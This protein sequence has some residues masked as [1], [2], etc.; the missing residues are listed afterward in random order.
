MLISNPFRR[1][2]LTL[3]VAFLVL[4]PTA[5]ARANDNETLETSQS[6]LERGAD[7]F[8]S[9]KVRPRI[10]F[11][12]QGMIEGD[13]GDAD[14]SWVRSGGSLSVAVPLSKSFVLV[15]RISG[16]I[17]NFSFDGDKSFLDAGQSGGDPFDDLLGFS[18][19]LDGRY[20]VA[21]HW[22]VL[23][24]V[25]LASSYE[26]GAS[27][28]DGS[29]FGGVIGGSY[30]P[31]RDFNVMLGVGVREKMTRD[32]ISI[33]PVFQVYWRPKPWLELET[34]G[35]GLRATAR[36]NP[37]VRLFTFGG[38]RSERH[39]LDDR[40]DGPNGVGKG[41]LRD[42][43]VQAGMGVEWRAHQRVRFEFDAGV[44]AYQ[45]LRVIDEDND[46]FDTEKMD[47]P[48]PFLSLRGQFRF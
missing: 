25:S 6:L 1:R 30:R 20:R 21:E 44:I 41:S 34:E 29:R 3:A 33:A 13:F 31:S 47:D 42:R 39:R 37:E 2:A 38:I 15:P 11:G 28:S 17:V 36:L 35:M 5:P 45:Q 22:A 27:F 9:Q 40:K 43:R 46:T 19:R 8:L 23:G 16:Q 18:F 32:S 24:G 48:A 14:V 7:L 12:S 26:D 4:G 10:F